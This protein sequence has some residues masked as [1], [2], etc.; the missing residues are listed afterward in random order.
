MPKNKGKFHSKGQAKDVAP[1]DEFISFTS[2]AVDFVRPHALKIGAVAGGVAAVLIAFG[3]WSWYDRRRETEATKQFGTA[4]ETLHGV[5]VGPD[6]PP[7]PTPPKPGDP[8]K[9]PSAKAR[10]EATLAV[11]SKMNGGADVT[12]NSRIIKAG[13]LYDLGRYDEAINEYKHF[14]ADADDDALKFVAREGIGYAQEAKALAEQDQAKRTAALDQALKTYEQLQPDEK[15][16]YRDVALY[17][18]A[19]IKALKGERDAAI[20]LYKQV[21]EKIPNTPLR[22]EI[23]NRLAV[24][25]Q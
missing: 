11:L 15:G 4:V 22:G 1:A 6:T 25:E 10:N 9:F 8:P 13:L 7:D 18:Q 20:A 16:F 17:H 19:R 5:V 24:L 2:R 3:I 21:I 23:N 12:Q 14:L